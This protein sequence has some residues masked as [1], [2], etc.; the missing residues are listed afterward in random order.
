MFTLKKS[1][2][3][4]DSILS[5][6]TKTLEELNTFVSTK[7]EENIKIKNDIVILQDNY[8]KEL[9]K[10]QDTSDTN[11][12]EVAKAESVINNIN[13]IIGK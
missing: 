8:K 5:G 9:T 6:F 13:N 1:I 11:N 10:L 3:S 12:N 2:K 7:K 4:L